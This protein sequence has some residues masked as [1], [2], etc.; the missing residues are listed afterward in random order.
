MRWCLRVKLAQNWTT[1]GDLLRSTDDLPLVEF[2][3]KDAFWG[4]KPQED[5][6]LVGM[7]VLGR[8]L[9]Q[10]REELQSAT[11]EHLRRVEPIPISDFLLDERPIGVIDA[12]GVTSQ[13]LTDPDLAPDRTFW[14]HVQE[15]SA[16]S[17][18]TESLVSGESAHDP[19]TASP[20]PVEL[21]LPPVRTEA[22]TFYSRCLPLLLQCLRT[23]EP[24]EKQLAG[25]A[26]KLDVLP[27]QFK[28]WLKR[29]L[30]DG[31]VEKRKKKQ[32]FVY[33]PTTPKQE[34]TLFD[35]GGDAA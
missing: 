9:M 1:F 20:P 3:R 10:L 8:L 26:Q 6:T 2:S 22:D 23:E 16:E 21:P 27:A 11:S 18:P 30:Q 13:S 12:G 31:K 7:N 33:L 15:P 29:A 17:S 4:A 34:A 32:K 14:N 24:S 25:I 28:K 5:R 35:S 19:D